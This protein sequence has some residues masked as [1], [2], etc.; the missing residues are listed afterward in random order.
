MRKI[1]IT[2]IAAFA[3]ATVALLP[4]VLEHTV[5]AE[6]P[7]PAPVSPGVPVTAG[8]V[9]AADV[10]VVLNGIGTVQ[11][12][13]MVTVRSRVDGQ[14]MEV[15]FTEGDEVKAGTPLFQIDPR[16]YQ[17]AVDQAEAAKGKDEAMLV[18]AQLDLDRYSQLMGTGFQTRQSYDQ[19]KAAVA[20]L[21]AALKGD[22][23][24]I[25]AAK[26]NW[27]YS[28]I[29]SPI[30][31]RL[32]A[33]LVDVGNLVH[34]TDSTGLVTITQLKPIFVSFTLSQD[35]LDAIRAQQA[36]GALVAEAYSADTKQKLASGKLTLI[37]NM[38]D[39]TTGT[40]HLKATFENADERLWPGEFVNMRLILDTRRGVPTVPD[41]TVQVGPTG[42][43]VYVIDKDNK[44]ERR[45]V[46]VAVVQDGIAVV[47]KGLTP[48]ERVVVDGQYRL[49]AGARIN[50]ISKPAA[51]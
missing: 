31:G 44:V 41:Q 38:V 3:G 16:P 28:L 7:A 45:P 42:R 19:Q 6:T 23:A 8:T 9:V 33:K 21:Q 34:A 47:T 37:D 40:I 46:D 18:S 49:T 22:T 36:K 48:G 51:G 24:A 2:A 32:G 12:F 25:E 11:A 4:S 10:P 43:Y 17:A 26:I 30:D 29:H 13:N 14:I 1:A 5:A 27:H 20:Q 50:A 15:D 39:Q 35:N